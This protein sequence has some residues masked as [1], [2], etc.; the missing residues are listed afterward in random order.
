MKLGLFL[1]ETTI[2]NFEEFLSIDNYDEF[3]LFKAR[4]LWLKQKLQYV[5]AGDARIVYS[6][7]NDKVFKLTKV[8]G[9]DQA[10]N[11]VNVFK[12]LGSKFVPKI[13][14]YSPDYSWIISE[15]VTPFKTNQELVDA[16]QNACGITKEKWN[17]LKGEIER[18][19]LVL[20][21]LLKQRLEEI[22]VLDSFLKQTSSWYRDFI[23][24]LIKCRAKASDL[25][26]DNAGIASD[27]RFVVLDTGSFEGVLEEQNALGAGGVVG[28]TAPLGA[29][30]IGSSNKLEKSFWRDKAGKKVK[31]GSPDL[32]KDIKE[33][34]QAINTPNGELNMIK[35]L[36]QNK[37]KEK[38]KTDSDQLHESTNQF[39]KCLLKRI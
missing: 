26:D 30:G 2:P 23:N 39:V 25:Y 24:I 6:I 17:E 34:V 28:Y 36:W 9:N 22:R 27:G 3:V 4:N 33:M 8:G 11:E 35:G 38:V 21:W 7:N 20:L 10:K 5:G 13:Y 32:D 19:T 15:K 16:F 31:T 29:P 37:E 14:D 12:C 1:F 18:D